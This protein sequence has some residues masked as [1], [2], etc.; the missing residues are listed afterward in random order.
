MN[1]EKLFHESWENALH[2][3][4]VALGGYKKVA[5][6]LWPAMKLDSAYAKLKGCL[7]EEKESEKL[8]LSEIEA[9]TRKGREIGVDSSAYHFCASTGYDKPKPVNPAEKKAELMEQVVLTGEVLK[10]LFAQLERYQ[11]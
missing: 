8:T 6:D 11:D 2:A 3:T 7:N 4:V 5:G 9:I 1:Q 10:G